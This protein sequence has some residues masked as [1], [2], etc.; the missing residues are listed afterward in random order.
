MPWSCCRY[1]Q[2]KRA[3]VWWRRLATK[4]TSMTEKH[5]LWKHTNI[6]NLTAALFFSVIYKITALLLWPHGLSS[7]LQTKTL[8]EFKKTDLRRRPESPGSPSEPPSSPGHLP[9]RLPLCALCY[10]YWKVGKMPHSLPLRVLRSSQAAQLKGF[11][12]TTCRPR[13]Q[14]DTRLVNSARTALHSRRVNVQLSNAGLVLPRDSA[15]LRNSRENPSGSGRLLK[16]NKMIFSCLPSR[17]RH[18]HMFTFFS[19]TFAFIWSF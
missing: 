13:A 1:A 5:Q 11:R 17:W 7:E 19:G 18:R 2:K 14:R 3:H 12:A 4:I 16:M 6:C 8:S 15:P 10:C 9:R